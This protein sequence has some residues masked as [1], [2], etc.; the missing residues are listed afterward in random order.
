MSDLTATES[1]TLSSFLKDRKF[2]YLKNYI[3]R[4]PDAKRSLALS[5]VYSILNIPSMSGNKGIWPHVPSVRDRD[6]Q[7]AYR[8]LLAVAK[9]LNNNAN[10]EL[11]QFPPGFRLDGYFG[12]SIIFDFAPP[13]F[14]S[15]TPSCS[16]YNSE[17]KLYRWKTF[18]CHRNTHYVPSHKEKTQSDLVVTTAYYNLKFHIGNCSFRDCICVT[19]L[20]DMIKRTAILYASSVGTTEGL[21]NYSL[22]AGVF[23]LIFIKS[24]CLNVCAEFP[25]GEHF[26]ESVV[27]ANNSAHPP[28]NTAPV[29]VSPSAVGTPSPTQ[30]VFLLN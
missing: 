3:C 22:T 15:L 6:T 18:S 26:R 21:Q 1:D 17:Y 25:S 16:D 19:S 13:A 24:Q 5:Y 29:A 9:L 2:S 4:L 20:S 27:Q 12:Q 10:E 8:F 30:N 23:S 14:E 7:I 28:L 11:Y